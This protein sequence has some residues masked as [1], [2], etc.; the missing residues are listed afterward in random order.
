MKILL[1]TSNPH[2][3]DEIIA[4]W[5]DSSLDSAMDENTPSIEWFDQSAVDPNHAIAEPVEDQPPFEGNAQLKARHYAV[6]AGMITLADDSGLEVD[7][8]GGQPGVRSA[9]YAGATGPR[10]QVDQANNEH[11]LKKLKELKDVPADQRT[12]RFVCA[13]AICVPLPTGQPACVVTTVRGTVEGR[14]IG[15]DESPRGEH[16]FYIVSDGTNRPARVKCRAPSFLA[17][18]ALAKMV[19]GGLIADVIA[20]I[21]STD[22]VM[23]DVAR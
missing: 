19:V 14:I 13:M 18:Q 4:I 16:G 15:P 17:C 5:R 21:G 3:L 22:V 1:A 2:K 6:A 10:A 12:A 9:R 7:A 11:L 8:L 20:V 23:G